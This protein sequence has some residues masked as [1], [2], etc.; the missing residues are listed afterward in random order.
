MSLL[1]PLLPAIFPIKIGNFVWHDLNE[2]GL[3]NFGEPGIEDVLV[4]LTGTTQSGGNVNQTQHTD[5]NGMY[6]FNKPATR[7]L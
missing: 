1:P 4:I 7:H 5:A 6:M 2:D 3:Q